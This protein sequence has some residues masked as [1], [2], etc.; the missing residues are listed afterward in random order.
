MTLVVFAPA[1]INL[2]LHVGRPGPDGRHPL[3]SLVAFADVGDVLEVTAT[4]DGAVSLTLD[5]PFAETLASDPDNLV[6]RAA[7]ALRAEKN[8]R[9]GAAI[10]LVKNLPIASGIGGGSS[11][12]AAALR[13]LNAVWDGPKLTDAALGD[14]GGALGADVPACIAAQPVRMLGDGRDLAPFVCP[15]L[16]AVLVNP[17]APAPT[18]AVYRAFDTLALGDTF[19]PSPSGPWA[20]AAAPAA[21]AIAALRTARND[22]EPAALEVAPAIGDVLAALAADPDI[23]LARLSGSGA[24]C[25]GLALDTASAM[26]AADRISAAQKRWWVRPTVLGGVDVRGRPA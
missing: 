26:R 2:T 3:D 21:D 7:R 5:G 15:P 24:T 8:A 9:R 14:I 19:A 25:F 1:K 11:D 20:N 6:L 16:A 18:G 23:A 4:D 12:A 17:G 10:R 13:A 22:L